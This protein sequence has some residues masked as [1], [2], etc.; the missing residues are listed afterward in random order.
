MGHVVREIAFR[1][2]ASSRQIRP[3]GLLIVTIFTLMFW[4]GMAVLIIRAI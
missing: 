1:A 4:T 3:S 2:R